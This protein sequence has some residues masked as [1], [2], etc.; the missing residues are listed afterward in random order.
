[1]GLG[2]G[3]RVCISNLRSDVAELKAYTLKSEGLEEISWHQAVG[4]GFPFLSGE[5]QYKACLSTE[6]PG[7]TGLR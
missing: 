6:V 2:W 3:L 1:M 5:V 4:G 7:V